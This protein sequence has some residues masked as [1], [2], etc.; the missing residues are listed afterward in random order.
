MAKQIKAIKCPHCGSIGKTEVKADHFICSSCNT[1]YFLDNDD[2]NINHNINYNTPNL[3]PVAGKKIALIIGIGLFVFFM[4]ILIIPAIFRSSSPSPSFN[5][6]AY[7]A[8]E[9][10]DFFWHYKETITYTNSKGEV[11]VL[12]FGNRNYMG[13][14]NKA[15]EGTYL[16][17]FNLLSDK[18]IK[19]QKI[20][21]I[22]EATHTNFE[23]RQ[24]PDGKIYGIANK[25]NVFE[26]DKENYT[27]S[28]VSQSLFKGHAKLASGIANAEFAYD[29][30]GHAFN[31][32]S[33]EGANVF[34]YPLE[35]K[36]YTKDEVYAAQRALV[37]KE[38]NEK[39]TT[40]FD[41]TSLSRDYPEEKIQLIRFTMKD[42]QGGPD[43]DAHLSWRN[44]HFVGKS[45]TSF[46][47]KF[48]RNF[49]D[50]TPGR[51]YFKPDI[52]YSDNDYVVITANKTAAEA[53]PTNI[54]C[55]DA[56]TGQLVFTYPFP[57]N[58][59]FEDAIRYKDGI[60]VT[61]Y[62]IILAIGLD[63]K[64]IKEFKIK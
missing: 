39:L 9:R 17:F 22:A 58:Q 63:G 38:P 52:L 2:I 4:M 21:G 57:T 59:R 33:N 23:L 13:N 28:D 6:S 27:A 61:S 3:N 14:D 36:I 48:V 5:K 41:F 43:D 24:F 46:G 49:V 25:T 31:L 60:V 37:V 44:D 8:P 16:S 54:Q 50:L 29:S 34:F 56:K 42:S 26:I 7:K 18:E 10:D 53:A 64:L 35:N 45:L 11:M 62:N 1:E 40:K 15:K 51:L 32:M 47:S 55:I 19:T 20:D 30:Y 12:I